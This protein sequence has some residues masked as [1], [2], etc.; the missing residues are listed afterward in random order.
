MLLTLV[1]DDCI[2]PQVDLK[3]PQI[4]ELLTLKC[5][6]FPQEKKKV[7]FWPHEMQGDAFDL[8]QQGLKFVTATCNQKQCFV[9]V[10]FF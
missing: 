9:L 8:L 2:S 1:S 10:F 5:L 3:K 7:L 6:F 4:P